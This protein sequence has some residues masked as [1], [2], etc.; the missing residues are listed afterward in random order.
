MST[1]KLRRLDSAKSDPDA[2][3]MQ[4]FMGIYGVGPAV[5]SKWIAQGHRTLQ[6]V[7]T[8]VDLTSN[9]RI[10]L[11]H[12]ADFAK[13]IPRAEVVEHARIIQET[14]RNLDPSFQLIV[15][16]SYRR[17]KSESGDIDCLITKEG[18]SIEHIRSILMESVIPYLT[19]T[20]FLK[21]TLASTHSRGDGSK[22]HGVSALPNIKVW[23]RID[24]LFVPW[25]ELGAALIYFTG[26][27]IFNRSIRLLASKRGMRL[28]Q[29]GLYKD[30][31]RGNQRER[32]TEGTLV[33]GHS[34]Q[35]I[36]ETLGVPWRPPQDRNC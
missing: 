5:A 17:G 36:L 26:N 18:A 2:Q 22:W 15:G 10:G 9:M 21:A 35:K 33:E 6:D 28:N 32:I 27:D 3:V 25:D 34:E 31:M 23:R 13:N 29:H 16:G 11:E 4:L 14:L 20:G 24:L 1:N 8:K 19:R 12:Y 7:G 30:V